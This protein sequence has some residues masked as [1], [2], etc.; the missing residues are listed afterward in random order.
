MNVDGGAEAQAR[1][2]SC[3][4]ISKSGRVRKVMKEVYL[5][6]D[7]PCGIEGCYLCGDPTKGTGNLRADERIL[8]PDAGCLLAFIDFIES[9]PCIRNCVIL[10]TILNKVRSK[11]LQVYGRLRGLCQDLGASDGAQRQKCF[12]M[13]TNEFFSQTFVQPSDDE[14]VKVYE[15][16]CLC[17]AAQWLQR[18]AA[19]LVAAT[20]PDCPDDLRSTGFPRVVI[21]THDLS[22]KGQAEAM[23][24]EV[25]TV[26]EYL[27][28][29]KDEFPNSGEQLAQLGDVDVGSLDSSARPAIYEAHWSEQRIAEGLKSGALLQ[30]KLRMVADCSWRGVVFAAE[31]E[32]RIVGRTNLNRALEGDVVAVQIIAA[33]ASAN[34]PKRPSSSVGSPREVPSV[35]ADLEELDEEA[36]AFADE[37]GN[38]ESGAES[39]EG[40]MASPASS[41]IREGRVV[42]IIR[43]GRREFCGTLKPIDKLKALS[44]SNTASAERV[45]VPADR[46]IPNIII[47]TRQSRDLD[48]KRLVVVLDSWDRFHRLPRGHWTEILGSFGDRQTEG[49]LILREQGSGGR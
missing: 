15:N 9:D 43:R 18:H 48:G 36:E 26:Y 40:E 37:E 13:F 24:L 2:L 47:K 11:N 46:R 25:Q 49:D 28:S 23:S 12:S 33:D 45:F 3:V 8:L 19:S 16:R 10:S 5:R 22:L 4:K 38:A 30:G 29:V 17:V 27:E 21:L 34:L 6:D 42:G 41:A 35:P 7:I 32:M 14:T 39:S 1:L 20:Q 44:M 31:E